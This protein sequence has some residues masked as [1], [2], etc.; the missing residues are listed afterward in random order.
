L[1]TEYGERDIMP[2]YKKK[3]TKQ[4]SYSDLIDGFQKREQEIRQMP[5]IE[6]AYL[7]FLFFVGCRVSESIAVTSDDITAT[8]ETIYVQI[9]RLKGSQQTDPN[10]I[11]NEGVL[12]WITEQ[13]GRIFPFSRFAA[14]RIVKKVFPELYPHYFRLNRITKTSMEFDDPTVYNLFGICAQT[15]DS[16]RGKTDIKRVSSSMK[17]EILEARRKGL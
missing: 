7:M 4:M 6:K 8:K 16:Y 2:R 9:H 10:E 17:A 15:I 13:K 1:K 14:R 11:P 12:Q 5:I 3:I